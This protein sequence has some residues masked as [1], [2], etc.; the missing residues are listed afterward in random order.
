LLLLPLP[1][2]PPPLPPLPPLLPPLRLHTHPVL[3]LKPSL[4]EALHELVEVVCVDVG[5][6]FVH[7]ARAEVPGH[8][9]QPAHARLD[10][11]MHHDRTRHETHD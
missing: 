7:K 9:E 5:P 6:D 4:L 10:E 3:A 2:L 11:S 8:A 1:P